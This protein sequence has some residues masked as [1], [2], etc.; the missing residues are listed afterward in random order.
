MTDLEVDNYTVGD[1]LEIFQIRGPVTR[2]QLV[3]AGADMAERSQHGGKIDFITFFSKATKRLLSS[4]DEVQNLLGRAL[5]G[6]GMQEGLTTL[7]GTAVPVY[8]VPK[9]DV[10]TEDLE[11]PQVPPG[12]E[13]L[14]QN[15]YGPPDVP[16][17]DGQEYPL[18]R[19]NRVAS[20]GSLGAQGVQLEENLN[21][22]TTYGQTPYVQGQLNPVVTNTYVSRINVDS[23]FRQIKPSANSSSC[24]LGDTINPVVE[25]E[26]TATDFSFPLADPVNNVI[27]M[28]LGSLEVPLDGYYAFSHEYGNITLDISFN[29]FPPNTLKYTPL[30]AGVQAPPWFRLPKYQHDGVAPNIVTYS[31]APYTWHTVTIPQGNYD[32]NQLTDQ[33]NDA[34]RRVVGPGPFSA[35]STDPGV[36][37][38]YPPDLYFIK[39]FVDPVSHKIQIMLN[40]RVDWWASRMVSI[41][42]Y[43]TFE[44]RCYKEGGTTDLYPHCPHADLQHERGMKINSNLGW[45]LGLNM[46]IAHVGPSAGTGSEEAVIAGP[47]R[48]GFQPLEPSVG[49]QHLT[50]V[51]KTFGR[52]PAHTS[53]CATIHW[54][55]GLPPPPPCPY[56]PDICA[57][58][59]ISGVAW[60]WWGI[61]GSQIVNTAGTSYLTLVV[62]DF[63]NNRFNGNMPGLPMPNSNSDIK[64]P[65][66]YTK[67]M[68]SEAACP[69]PAVLSQD[70]REGATDPDRI[71]FRPATFGARLISRNCRGGTP[72]SSPIVD[73]SSNLTKA[74]KYTVE[75]ILNRRVAFKENLYV[76]PMISNVLEKIP[77]I[78]KNG[79]RPTHL[80]YQQSYFTSSGG[81]G[82]GRRYFGKVNINKLHIKLLDDKG[83]PINLNGGELSF[84]LLLERIYQF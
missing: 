7:T 46:E 36:P 27:S 77:I 45:S 74:Q 54:M 3:E 33:L 16:A 50:E 69:R 81:R 34:I 42:D 4:Y 78:W 9:P 83:N 20:P 11:P 12:E 51:A 72:N 29:W 2:E 25:L 38:Y 56:Q 66:Y 57:L 53:C 63:N 76:A 70:F 73:G 43:P 40:G 84:S 1:L 75:Q 23:Q 24:S 15:Y 35:A 19:A 68:A 71:A 39:T 44:I 55:A 13:M 32:V 48:G 22:G 17:Q 47:G 37:Y 18:N 30:P 65:Y 67:I 41:H 58:Y 21:I 28:T 6:E 61:Q 60:W 79:V 31:P 59:D 14:E 5:G 49:G 64:M 52:I 62:E 8:L 10:D 82:L 80:H 26:G